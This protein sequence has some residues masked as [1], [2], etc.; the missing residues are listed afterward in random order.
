METENLI[1][2]DEPEE[3]SYSA[4]EREI[5]RRGQL[6][7]DLSFHP[8]WKMFVEISEAQQELRKTMLCMPRH[9]RADLSGLTKAESQDADEFVKG[10]LYGI[11]L[12]IETIEGMIQERK[13]L[14]ASKNGED[15]E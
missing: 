7:E 15:N 10:V 14:L 11:G 6:A 1:N 9:Q 2:D 12:N 8:G 13:D 4:D 5:L 3:H